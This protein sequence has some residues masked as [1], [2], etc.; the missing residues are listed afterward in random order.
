MNKELQ[1]IKNEIARV[2]NTPKGERIM[3]GGDK[4]HRVICKFHINNN[5]DNFEITMENMN[6]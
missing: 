4:P 3:F 5:D 2:L 1:I 6:V